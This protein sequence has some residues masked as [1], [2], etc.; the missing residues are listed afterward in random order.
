MY[1][2]GNSAYY[3]E[4]IRRGGSK[5]A[6]LHDPPSLLTDRGAY[7]NFLEVQLERV[8]AACL[9]VSSYDDRFNDMQRLVVNLEEKIQLNTQMLGLNQRHTEET[10]RDLQQKVDDLSSSMS[11]R[12]DSLQSDVNGI[13]RDLKD[14][15]SELADVNDKLSR[16]E[17]DT[18]RT[19]QN[20]TQQ[21]SGIDHETRNLCVFVNTL[22]ETVANTKADLSRMTFQVQEQSSRTKTQIEDLRSKHE[23]SLRDLKEEMQLKLK[24]VEAKISSDVERL[25]KDILAREIEMISSIR[26]FKDV[27]DEE[28]AEKAERAAK[29]VSTACMDEI[30]RVSRDTMQRLED[31]QRRLGAFEEHQDKV[32]SAVAGHFDDFAGSIGQLQENWKEH[33]AAFR[34]LENAVEGTKSFAKMQSSGA[35][36]LQSKLERMVRAQR[37]KESK[38]RL[39]LLAHPKPA[40]TRM[41]AFESE[42]IP[43]S[44]SQGVL[45]LMEEQQAEERGRQLERLVEAYHRD[46]EASRK[47]L[48]SLSEALQPKG[49]PI[50]SSPQSAAPGEAIPVHEERKPRGPQEPSNQVEA[51]IDSRSD[52]NATSAG[53]RSAAQR[54]TTTATPAPIDA[55]HDSTVSKLPERL[56]QRSRNV[57]FE[58]LKHKGR[59]APWI[60]PKV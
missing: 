6:T 21:L 32:E 31:L 58:T 43:K 10:K 57:R 53:D 49:K 41:R 50:V 35:R 18:K 45:G 37:A 39:S 2:S 34:K 55:S 5:N 42:G 26:K 29:G 47:S 23:I 9:S 51:T 44:R 38:R 30:A 52:A 15:R 16:Q 24:A 3:D 25:E 13:Y 8:S 28:Y 27:A 19:A 48:E 20:L 54:L 33:S 60:P 14:I 36:D 11:E 46:A 4:Y 1:F 40:A 17:E 56:V 22:G 59:R 7:V 12:L